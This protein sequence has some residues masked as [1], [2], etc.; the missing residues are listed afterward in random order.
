MIEINE[1]LLI[2]IKTA[3][4]DGIESSRNLMEFE[5]NQ[6][7]AG[8]QRMIELYKKEAEESESIISSI[9]KLLQDN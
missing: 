7:E 4:D 5:I 2:R 8:N 3:L 1:S 9:S 6:R